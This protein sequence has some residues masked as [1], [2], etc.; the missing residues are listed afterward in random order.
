MFAPMANKSRTASS[1]GWVEG[2][3]TNGTGPIE[4]AYMLYFMSTGSGGPISSAWTDSAGHYNL[5]VLG[6]IPYTVIA[7]NGS[8]YTAGGGAAPAVGQSVW[9]NLT[10]SPIAPLVA[11]VILTGYVLDGA[12]NPVAGGNVA[13]YVNDPITMGQGAPMYGNMTTADLVTGRYTVN[14]IPGTAGGGVAALD[15]PGYNFIDN[16]TQD[17]FVSGQTYWINITLSNPP[18][19]DD[20][21]LSGNVTDGIT[22]APLA[23]VFVSIESQNPW[24]GQGGYS[25]FTL[26]NA[27]GYYEMNVTNG[28][29][30]L[31]FQKLHYSMYEFRD[32]SINPGAHV[33]VDATLAAANA[34]VRGNV[35]DLVT[36]LPL[37]NVRVYITDNTG[38]F[39]MTS[40]NSLGQYTLEAFAAP[41]EW[42]GAEANG[43]SRNSS[44]ITI[45]PGDNLWKDL[46]LW[47][48][49]AWMVGS[50]T[51]L[52]TGA[53]IAN[54]S[55]WIQSSV[56]NNYESTNATGEYNFTLLSGNYSVQVHA[57]SYSSYSATVNVV[58][59]GN[60]YDIALMPQNPPRTTRL[61]GW[62][63]D[64]D[65]GLGISNA[66]VR[67]GL[68][69]PYQGNS[70]WNATTNS[71][72][73][74]EMWA[75]PTMIQYTATA[76]N[77]VHA[78]GLVDA[79]GLTVKRL[80][81]TLG[82]DPWGPNV[83]YAQSPRENISWTHPSWITVTV[84]EK[85]PNQFVLA[86]FMFVN[87]S[88]GFSDYA[89]VQ[90]LYDSFDPLN[91]G[92]NNLPFTKT[93]DEYN[94]SVAWKATTTGGLLTS[95]LTHQYF[96]SYESGGGP[97][98]YQGLRA[99]YYNSTLGSSHEGS[100]WFDNSTGSFAFFSFDN[101]SMPRAFPSDTTG[102][103]APQVSVVRVNDTTNSTTWINRLT[104]GT[105]SV[106]GLQFT[107][108]TTLPSGKYLTE[109]SVGDFGN[110]GAGNVTFVTVD[111]DPPVAN[112]GFDQTVLAGQLVLFDGASSTDNV[113][114]A[115]Y[116][117][118]IDNGGT[119]VTRWGPSPTFSFLTDGVYNVTLTVRDGA[120]H[121]S[122]DVMR[123][124]VST[125]IPEFPAVIIPISGMIMIIALVRMRRSRLP[126]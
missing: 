76:T 78:E 121:N 51:D 28:T 15:F 54:A 84:Q 62:V 18:S 55:I 63:N 123:V 89:L 125:V 34:T 65:S 90:M 93:G 27:S 64:S 60:N 11:D 35:T 81:V 106:V 26:T 102:T 33:I 45:L 16:T 37:S 99:L 71:T 108:D 12:G 5:T 41:M 72:G 52:I 115:N 107:Y 42:I 104:E 110:R 98:V 49:D 20:A 44:L 8:Y 22:G 68:A 57:N 69:A 105:W 109:F 77:H 86:H 112:A 23:D 95:G 126:E 111:N 25:N 38:N 31:L 83:T 17:P 120:G 6:G 67:V 39:T 59:G 113:G 61:Y 118:I 101:G 117:W 4:H 21:I 56:Y 75:P 79:T 14:V 7:F 29:S 13:G 80:D 96:G 100:A 97:N 91:Q 114:V 9:L 32:F 87:A 124:T 43:Y 47:P 19:T 88:S 58:P 122:T 2:Q 40:T 48:L 30:R 103:I 74:Y 92:A 119:P 94:I 73:Y 66:E 1:E 36:G 24:N 46:G 3:V 53:P 116:T 10:M 85:D 70:I 82:P 50:V